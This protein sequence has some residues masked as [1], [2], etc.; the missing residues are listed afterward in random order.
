LGVAIDLREGQFIY[1]IIKNNSFKI[2]LEIG[3]ASGLSSV[4]ICSA[5]SKDDSKHIII[6]PYQSKEYHSIGINLL[7][8]FGLNNFV[9]IEEK[10]EIA[11]PHLLEQNFKIDFA[12]IDG[13]HT[14]DHTLLDFFYIDKLLNV[15]GIVVIDDVQLPAIKKVIHYISNYDN[16]EIIDSVKTN[17]TISRHLLNFSKNILNIFTIFLGRRIKAE[18]FDSSVYRN[19]KSLKLYSSMI[20][21]KKIG[22]DKREWNWYEPF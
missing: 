4:F 19:D 1:N 20:A 11:L 9:L 2:T 14:F 17:Q 18:F 22:E 13:W 5:L 3:C 12:L 15:N 8:K 6:D 16:Y 10:S 7:R 21:L